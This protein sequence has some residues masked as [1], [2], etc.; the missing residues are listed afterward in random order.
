MDLRF[1]DLRGWF[2]RHAPASLE[3]G[4]GSWACDREL[5]MMTSATLIEA[6]YEAV[7]D[8]LHSL[9]KSNITELTSKDSCVTV[10]RSIANGHS[11]VFPKV[12]IS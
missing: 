1:A 4:A 5:M 8:H 12:A 10:K 9:G 7:D 6:L 2:G 3:N 11:L